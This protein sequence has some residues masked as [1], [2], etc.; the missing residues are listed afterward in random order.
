[1]QCTGCGAGW[2]RNYLKNSSSVIVLQSDVI[3][4]DFLL[5]NQ[6]EVGYSYV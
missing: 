4:Q 5:V 2:I 6:N 1:M 3:L